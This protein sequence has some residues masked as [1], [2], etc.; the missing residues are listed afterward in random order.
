MITIVFQWVTFF[1]PPDG[2]Q[3][4]YLSTG[5]GANGGGPT[6]DD[7]NGDGDEESDL[8]SISILFDAGPGGELTFS[9]NLLTD[10]VSGGVE[11]LVIFGLDGGPIFEGGIDNPV[12]PPLFSPLGPFVGPPLLGPDG[13][14]FF[15]G[16]LGF[17]TFTLAGV[18]PGFRTLD[19]QVLD[20]EDDVVDTALLIDALAIDGS[21]FESFE[22]DTLGA[23]PDIDGS[24]ITAPIPGVLGFVDNV[25]VQGETS[26]VVAA[27]PEPGTL[28]LLGLG[29]V[30]LG[31]RARP[32]R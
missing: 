10:E 22:T 27:V 13:S 5:P 15:D 17:T 28:A 29:L 12:D 20:D 31:A 8:A 14:F 32:R 24:I 19:L 3:F 21:I 30:V 18:G 2:L 4:L 23:P 16:E 26:F 6:G 7:A 1:V 11:D 25:T 9:F